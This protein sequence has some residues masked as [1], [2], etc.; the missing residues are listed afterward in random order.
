[1]PKLYLFTLCL[2]LGAALVGVRIAGGPL[3][4]M[5][6]YADLFLMGAAFLLLETK[7]IVQFALL[8]GTT[9]FVNA[10]VVGGILL[11]VLAAIEVA[12]RL[13]RGRERRL[14]AALYGALFASLAL[15]WAIPPDDLLRLAW[16]VRLPAA[17]ALAFAPIL[18]ANLVFAERFR[19]VGASTVAFGAN[20]LGAMVGGLLEYTAIVVGY[21]SLLL[22]TAG[23]YAGAFALGHLRAPGRV[24]ATAGRAP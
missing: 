5:R 15:A 1:M 12:S 23:L 6:P 19:D 4:Q 8:F 13:P 2:I 11:V 20:L 22:L 21:R 7:N 24:A 17:I 16:G 10:L 3:G 18:F 14:T 9:W